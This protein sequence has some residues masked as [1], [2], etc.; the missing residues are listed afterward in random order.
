MLT[1]TAPSFAGSYSPDGLRI[2]FESSRDENSEVYVMNADG[3]GQ[4]RLTVGSADN[5]RPRWSPDGSR[6]VFASFRDGNNEVYSMNTDGTGVQRLT[7][8]PGDDHAPA[9]SPDGLRIVFHSMRSGNVEIC[10]AAVIPTLPTARQRRRGGHAMIERTFEL[11]RFPKA[12]ESSNAADY[13][14]SFVADRVFLSSSLY[15][16]LFGAPMRESDDR[17]PWR[18][19]VVRVSVRQKG[20][21]RSIRRVFIG[22]NS[23]RISEGQIGL[24]LLSARRSGS[25]SGARARFP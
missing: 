20:E 11:V 3:T 10:E 6:I 7:N 21:F 4:S 5:G 14:E 16:K 2:A 9:W 23:W 17:Q 25:I 15:A 13:D 22:G 8:S 18:R 1:N 24:D 12:A 19:G